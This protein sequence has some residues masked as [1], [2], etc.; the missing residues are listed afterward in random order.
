VVCLWWFS[1]MERYDPGLSIIAEAQ[2]A[3]EAGKRDE[4]HSL[5]VEG[6]EQLMKICHTEKNEK[7]KKLVRTHVRRFMEEA[8]S[9]VASQRPVSRPQS[10]PASQ[11][12]PA[13]QVS[14]K[15]KALQASAQA[16]EKRARGAERN[17]KFLEAFN[18]YTEA[19]SQYKD[20]RQESATC[21]S[22]R[23]WA[24]RQALAMIEG[25]ERLQRLLHNSRRSEY[26]TTSDDGMVFDLPH[27]PG[28]AAAAADAHVPANFAK[29][30][31]MLPNVLPNSLTETFVRGRT[32][33]DAA[34]QQVLRM[35]DKINGKTYERMHVT[36]V[37]WHNFEGSDFKDP[38]GQPRL[39]KKQ[40]DKGAVWARPA[41]IFG[42]PTLIKFFT[43]E[44]ITQ[45]LVGDCSFVSSLAVC[46]AWE[47]RFGRTLISRNIYPQR[48]G[49]PVLS[50]SGKYIVKMY[51]N[52]SVRKISIDDHLPVIPHSPSTLL[53]SFSS[54][55][56]ELWVSLFEKAYIKLHGGYDF[57]GSTSS[58]D[59]HALCGWIPETFHLNKDSARSNPKP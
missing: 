21:E 51:L 34:E 50:P 16:V 35:G 43:F 7:T 40:K 47:R 42:S 17:L 12:A 27:V 37:D 58:I 19:A 24:G 26:A 46:A 2:Q 10:G 56:D 23:A 59:L 54:S 52:G 53:C 48:N 32:T 25:A 9:L 22:L 3:R 49:V 45:T 29:P 20:L 4:A 55:G 8:E 15:A 36:D 44:S 31:A 28:S 6:I 5:F 30:D 57:P 14:P 33:R 18:A 13:D 11:G 38:D 41:Q 39:S 1:V